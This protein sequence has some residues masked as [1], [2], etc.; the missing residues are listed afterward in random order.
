MQQTEMVFKYSVLSPDGF[1]IDRTDLHNTPELAWEAFELWK[2]NFARQGF[3]STVRQG[4]RMS[5][6]LD[7]LKHYC[8]MGQ[9]PATDP[10]L[11]TA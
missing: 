10:Q 4:S 9:F 11:K 6:P 7:E 3:Y 8:A 2:E 1:T 5:I